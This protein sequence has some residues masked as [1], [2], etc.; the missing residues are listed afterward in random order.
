M[1]SGGARNIM[2]ASAIFGVVLSAE[3]FIQNSG[4][5]VSWEPLLVPLVVLSG[6][7]LGD[8]VRMA[9]HSV[10]IDIDQGEGVGTKISQIETLR[11]ASFD[12][13][14]GLND[15][16][17]ELKEAIIIPLL[18][19][20]LAKKYRRKVSTI[21]TYLCKNGIKKKQYVFKQEKKTIKE[22]R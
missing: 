4:Y 18:K 22:K 15:V 1:K 16:K 17:E 9:F 5:L 10:F 13:V 2:L 11:R 6:L 3:G 8:M 14:G 12:L 7:M 19:P 20:E 21:R